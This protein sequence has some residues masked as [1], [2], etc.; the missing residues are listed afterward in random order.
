MKYWTRNTR[1]S[2]YVER[3]EYEKLTEKYKKLKERMKIIE[4]K[5]NNS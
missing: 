1:E 4:N 2:K 5:L 3:F